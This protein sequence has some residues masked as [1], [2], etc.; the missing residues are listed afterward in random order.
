[1]VWFHTDQTVN[2]TFGTAE[3][4]EFKKTNSG[5]FLKCTFRRHS[6]NDSLINPSNKLKFFIIFF[7]FCHNTLHGIYAKFGIGRNTQTIVLRS[8]D[9][10]LVGMWC[11]ITGGTY[12]RIPQSKHTCN[13]ALKSFFNVTWILMMIPTIFLGRW[14][15]FA[16]LADWRVPF[17]VLSESRKVKYI[18]WNS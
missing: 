13:K 5:L 1:M 9:V 15:L 11:L 14:H 3:S 17:V 2:I 10:V 16:F 4:N 18:S 12:L 7:S 6:T 8:S